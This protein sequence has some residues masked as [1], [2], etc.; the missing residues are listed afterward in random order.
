M[1]ANQIAFQRL[2][3]ERRTNRAKEAIDK[4][5]AD[6][7]A[8]HNYV[9]EGLDNSRNLEVA[10]HNVISESLETKALNETSRSNLAREG[11][12]YRHN[13]VSETSSIGG[14]ISQLIHEGM[15]NKG[16]SEWAKEFTSPINFSDWANDFGT[17]RGGGVLNDV[18]YDARQAWNKVTAA[19][20]EAHSH[21][22]RQE[23][24][25]QTLNKLGVTQTLNSL[26]G[27][28]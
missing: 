3:E 18:V 10:R 9:Q 22:A 7:I 17:T 12:T 21:K 26:F 5:K 6:E 24:F 8:R 16:L 15:D 20:D 23:T 4:A 11:E 28:N 25:K 19:Y 1:T 2:V 27:G 13:Q 14:A